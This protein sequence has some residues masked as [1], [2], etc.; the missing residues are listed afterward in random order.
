ML[1][2][3]IFYIDTLLTVTF[4]EEIESVIFPFFLKC[5][6]CNHEK[7]QKLAL[8]RLQVVFNK[9]QKEENIKLLL[10]KLTTFFKSPSES[11]VYLTLKFIEENLI[12]FEKGTVYGVL[13]EQLEQLILD[14]RK[15]ENYVNDLIY[16]IFFK[17]YKNEERE[18]ADCSYKYLRVFLMII[19][20]ANVS[21]TAFNQCF[22]IVNTIM[23]KLRRREMV[24]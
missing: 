22:N 1:Y 23:T 8:C 7:I 20:Q 21:K 5:L 15:F 11:L 12:R 14:S 9:V 13:S 19:G 18:G 10:G 17:V 24:G 4:N 2:T 3:L 16:K 6:V